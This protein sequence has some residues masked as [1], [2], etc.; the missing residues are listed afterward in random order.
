[1]KSWQSETEIV[2]SFLVVVSSEGELELSG[3]ESSRSSV[4]FFCVFVSSTIRFKAVAAFM[5]VS[6]WRYA[7]ISWIHPTAVNED[8]NYNSFPTHNVPL[9]MESSALLES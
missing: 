6:L 2:M 4:Q 7:K 1:M 5:I 9:A 8:Q 3:S